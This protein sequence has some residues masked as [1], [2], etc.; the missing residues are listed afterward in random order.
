MDEL[1][2]V[3]AGL[4]APGPVAAQTVADALSDA[5]AAAPKVQRVRFRRVASVPETDAWSSGLAEK[6]RVRVS[7]HT[8]VHAAAEAHVVPDAT[9]LWR[10]KVAAQADRRSKDARSS[11]SARRRAAAAPPPSSEAEL[12]RSFRIYD[13]LSSAPAPPDAAAAAAGAPTVAAAFRLIQRRARLFRA[14]DPDAA[15]RRARF[16]PLVA[17]VR[18]RILNPFERQADEAVW[19]AFTTGDLSPV[20]EALRGGADVNYQRLHSDLTTALMAASFHGDARAAVALLRQGA[21][22]RIADAS[23][24]SAARIAEERGHAALA[25]L[26]RDVQHEEEEEFAAAVAPGPA[27]RG[28]PL[29]PAPPPSPAAGAEMRDG[30]GAEFDYDVFV[31]VDEGKEVEGEGEER[32][33]AADGG[34]AEGEA[35]AG[36]AQGDAAPAPVPAVPSRDAQPQQVL[37]LDDL[38]LAALWGGADLRGTLGDDDGDGDAWDDGGS[39]CVGPTESWLTAHCSPKPHGFCPAGVRMTARTAAARTRRVSARASPPLPHTPMT[40]RPS[41]TTTTT[42]AAR[43][44][45]PGGGG[46]GGRRRGDWRGGRRRPHLH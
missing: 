31:P 26:L 44:R 43:Q 45:V 23:G 29:S 10:S 39:E 38:S 46:R 24:R 36:L 5:A 32:A 6:L 1:A 15:D 40:R 9:A 8:G 7:R 30:P 25:A 19:R 42:A 20:F 41:P 22:A 18:G 21:L 37:L 4:A 13:V 16:I 33:A 17:P 14:A 27:Q 35:A 2:R 34:S 11:E 3:M 28:G 12:R